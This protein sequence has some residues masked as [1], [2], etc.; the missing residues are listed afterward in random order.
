MNILLTG[1][2]SGIGF[3][4]LK[5]L[6]DDFKDHHIFLVTRKKKKE[7]YK[8]KIKRKSFR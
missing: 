7:Y 3:D 2:F 6:L 5:I 4:I 8:K 1:G